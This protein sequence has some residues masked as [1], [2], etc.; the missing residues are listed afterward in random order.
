[1]AKNSERTRALITLLRYRGGSI[2]LSITDATQTELQHM[3]QQLVVD[4]LVERVA[5]S[6]AIVTYRLCEYDLLSASRSVEGG[7]LERAA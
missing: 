7:L 3:L 5:S 6:E 1:M 2:T 4:G